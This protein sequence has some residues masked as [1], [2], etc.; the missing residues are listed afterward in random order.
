MLQTFSIPNED[1]RITVILI[2]MDVGGTNEGGECK[3]LV[4]RYTPE[5]PMC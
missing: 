3:K 5:S 2:A 4:I 1:G